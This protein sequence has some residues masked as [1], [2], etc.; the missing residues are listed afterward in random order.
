MKVLY[1]YQAFYAQKFGGVSNSFVQL[2]KNLP[3]DVSYEVAVEESNNIHL[4]ESGIANV[5][6]CSLTHENFITK[7]NFKGRKLLYDKFSYLFPKYT[8]QGRN[9]LYSIE[10]LRKGDYD[11]FHPTFFEDYF[12]PYLEKK[13]FVLTVHDM[14]PE[15]FP[16]YF[17]Q[18][19][20]E[21]KRKKLLCEKASAIIAVS[22][23]TKKDLVELFDIPE[24]KINVIY[25]G[26]PE[27]KEREHQKP[28][29]EGRY[30]LYVGQRAF[31]KFFVEML[32][33]I[34]PFMKNTPDVKIVC[35]GKPFVKSELE[36]IH[37]LGLD[38]RVIQTFADDN[39]LFNLYSH[40]QCFVY[41]SIYEGFGIPILEA[42]EAKCPVLLN[43]KSCFPEIA[44]DAAVFFNL[45]KNGSDL[46]D[47]ITR[48]F[49]L[50]KDGRNALI[51]KQ[52]E[53]LRCFSWEKSAKLLAEVYAKVI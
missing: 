49:A 5:R 16:Q 23:N 33:S 52:S 28:I 27:T 9:R 46:F 6:P 41:S 21:K 43:N 50:N 17:R 42:Y 47:V 45:D 15:L 36:L 3:Q 29:I 22:E 39:A 4:K 35:T 30:I 1:D 32:E 34:E 18:P 31:Y 19:K 8:S 38:D 24:D 26:A 11:V 2:I 25:H 10:A 12:L 37:K 44:N 7:N 48:F 20:L 13:P 53:R 14:M 51:E 40:A